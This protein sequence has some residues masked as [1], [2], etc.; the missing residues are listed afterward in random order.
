MRHFKK[1]GVVH[2]FSYREVRAIKRKIAAQK[3]LQ[4][5]HEKKFHEISIKIGAL[6]QLLDEDEQRHNIKKT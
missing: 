6:I 3:G 1:I 2:R 4:N 5:E